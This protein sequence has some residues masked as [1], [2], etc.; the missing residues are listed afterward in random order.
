MMMSSSGVNHKNSLIPLEEIL[1]ATRN[2]NSENLIREGQFSKV[3]RG[4]L[5]GQWQ[6]RRV[7]IK[8]FNKYDDYQPDT[9]ENELEMV[10]SLNHE[11]IIPYIGN[12]CNG[13]EMILVSEYAENGSLDHY[14]RD[15][16]NRPRLTWAQRLKICLGAARALKYLHSGLGDYKRVIHRDFKSQNILL[17]KNLEAKICGFD[18]SMLI[19]PKQPI[20]YQHP[21]ATLSYL[22]PVYHE[23]GIVN[24]ESDVY[25]LGVVLFE[26]L[27]GMLASNGND[28]SYVHPQTLINLVR[29][30]YDDG[31]DKLIASNE[32]NQFDIRSFHLFKEIAYKC[33]SL[34][35]EE[36]PTMGMIVDM[37]KQALAIENQ[38]AA[39]T[40]IALSQPYQSQESF[41][42][43]PEEIRLATGYF[44]P[45]SVITPMRPGKYHVAHVG[46]LSE[47]WQN[48]KAIF[49]WFFHDDMPLFYNEVQMVHRFQNENVI[50]FIGYCI[51]HNN[52]FLVNEY[53]ING[54]LYDHLRDPIKRGSL[55]WEKRLEI[56]IGAARGIKYLHS[57]LGE[58]TRVIHRDVKS[59][60]ILLADK[61]EAKI[62]GFGLSVL[63]DPYQPQVYRLVEGTE[64]YMDPVYSDSGIVRTESDIYSFGVVM[65]EMLSGMLAHEERS[66]GNAPP[67]RLINL[68]RF[69][70]DGRLD[71]LFDPVIRDES[72]IDSIKAFKK[73]A[74]RCISLNIRDRPTMNRIVSRIEEARD[75][76]HRAASSITRRSRTLESYLIP[77]K[78]IMLAT[79]D[80][81]RDNWRGEGGFGNIYEGHLSERWHNCTVAIKTHDTQGYQGYD[82]FHTELKCISSFFHENIIPFVG[83]CDEDNHMIIVT[84]YASNQSLDHHL[85]DLHKRNCLTWAHR[86]K[87]CLGAARGLGYLHSNGVIHRDIKSG[88]ILLDKNMEAKICDFGLSKKNFKNQQGTHI[89]T[90]PAGT[91]FYLDPFYRESG[92]LRRVSDVYSFGVVLFEILSG[93]MA[94]EMRSIGNGK[95][96][97]LMN[98]VRQ[99]YDNKLETLLDPC[100]AN[101]IDSRS[102]HTFKEVAYKCISHIPQERP[103]MDIIIERIEDAMDFQ[104]KS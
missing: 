44:G 93:I 72:N 1:S 95:P 84:E 82:E 91:N 68:V 88:N 64:S 51:H 78:E 9:L 6:Y 102:F 58:Q 38:I 83:Y 16:M 24:T 39:S 61:M 103:T 4:I 40:I 80:F 81:S 34:K 70:D 12:Y 20:V 89:Y 75:I 21:M 31:L 29:N 19:D 98:L 57:G 41:L 52:L 14:L 47:G 85:R 79:K 43:P 25:S 8:R 2:F 104:E 55:T 101:Q 74:Y 15:N 17:D 56:C 76:Q 10:S 46:Q 99:L 32:R 71:N 48:R 94:Y 45:E 42:I 36:R 23:S 87:I 37:F 26:M 92:I 54:S 5:S 7:A 97:R 96:K 90:N 67:Q 3:Y 30:C 18:F 33:I 60:R 11:N 28:I 27:N 65:F 22:D 66:I 59:A 69:Y 100:I 63:I 35:L 13:K 50:S 62:S 73:I 53:A 86:L 49:R 77:L